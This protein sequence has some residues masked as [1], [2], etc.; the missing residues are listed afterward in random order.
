[1]TNLAHLKNSCCWC[2]ADL[3]HTLWEADVVVF[4]AHITTSPGGRVLD[5]FW[6][7]DHRLELPETHRQAS[8][9]IWKL[10]WLL[11]QDA[12]GRTLGVS[13]VFIKSQN[14]AGEHNESYVFSVF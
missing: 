2:G 11:C 12:R 6:I 3:M 7:H 14:K 1:M 13:A 8:K 4:K 5:M 10:L 9:P